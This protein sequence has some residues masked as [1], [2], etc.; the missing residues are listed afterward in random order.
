M[1]RSDRKKKQR[2]PLSNDK[3]QQD[4]VLSSNTHV[5]AFVKSVSKDLNS[6]QITRLVM[7]IERQMALKKLS[8]TA[9]SDSV[10]DTLR[11][12]IDAAECFVVDTGGTGCT[13]NC[14][15]PTNTPFEKAKTT[16]SIEKTMDILTVQRPIHCAITLRGIKTRNHYVV[17]SAMKNHVYSL[18]A[19]EK[20]TAMF[21]MSKCLFCTNAN[22][23]MTY[24]E[25]LTDTPTQYTFTKLAE[26][27]AVSKFNE[28]RAPIDLN[29]GKR[30]RRPRNLQVT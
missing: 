27:I 9:L 29:L 17:C 3:C 25:K 18:S 10:K 5:D 4:V 22:V 16:V 26:D 20:Y 30:E 13:N 1:T 11:D 21:G 12:T 8:N 6:A 28:L 2:R 19:W 7:C 15:I 23:P 14:N 24:Y